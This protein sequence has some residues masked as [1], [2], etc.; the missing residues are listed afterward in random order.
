[1]LILHRICM[2]GLPLIFL[3]GRITGKPEVMDIAQIWRASPSDSKACKVKA[4]LLTLRDRSRLARQ[5]PQQA[6]LSVVIALVKNQPG[7]RIADGAG[8]RRTPELLGHGKGQR[9]I[10]HGR[11]GRDQ[12]L[13]CAPPK[14][15]LPGRMFLIPSGPDFQNLFQV[16]L[17]V[18][19][20]DHLQRDSFRAVD[21][22]I[23]GEFRNGPEAH[24]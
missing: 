8:Q 2:H 24:R 1:M 12:L 11:Q 17:S 3:F 5:S 14:R 18:Q 15:V 6:D 10:R 7:E 4:G 21:D 9:L 23:I 19:Y 22:H 16:P 13:P 20:G